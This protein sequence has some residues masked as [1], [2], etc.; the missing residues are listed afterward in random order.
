VIDAR[1][2]RLVRV[3]DLRTFRDACC[4]LA[5]GGD[6]LA[7]R[8]RLVI[9]P[10]RA[11][12]A[13]LTRAIEQ[14][15][16]P[17]DGAVLL[18]DFVVR[19]TL[20][21]RLADR[22]PDRP[23]MLTPFEREALMGVACR[24]AAENGH[25]PPFQLRPGLV[26]E[27][28]SFYDDLRRHENDVATFERK[29]LD[30]LEPGADADRGAERLVRQTRFLAEAFRNFEWRCLAEGALDEHGLR[31]HLR[32]TPAAMPW[33]HL[34]ITVR[35]RASDPHG[36]WNCDFDLLARLPGLARI[37]L[38]VTETCLAGALHER[39]HQVFPGIEE[40]RWSTHP[41]PSAAGAGSGPALLI[42]HGTGFAHV[43]RDREEEVAD[44]ARRVR[45]LASEP[46]ELARGSEPPVLERMALV[47][48]RPLP[49]VYLAQD[50]MRSAAV[51]CQTFDALPLAAE[52][53]AAALDLVFSC[54][55]ANFARTSLVAMLQSPHFRFEYGGG[56][57]GA[58]EV[59]ALD[60]ALSEAGYLGDRATLESV[61]A[62][63]HE[64]EGPLVERAALAGTVAIDVVR[65]LG[66]LR[67]PCAVAAHVD[68]LLAF[69]ERH[70]AVP[71]PDDPLRARQLRARAAIRAALHGIRA[72][73]AAYD[74]AAEAFE[75]VAAMVRRWI[76]SYTF[77]PRA[78]ESGVH[79]VDAESARYGD[80]DFV[81]LAGLVEGEWPEPPR[82]SIFYASGVLQ[83]LGWAAE[84]A[85][86]EGARNAFIDLLRLPLRRLVVSTFTLEDDTIVAASPLLDE[87][88]R[89]GLESVEKRI[90]PRPRTFEWEALGLEPVRTDRLSA[91]ALPW[92]E[93]RLS[94]RSSRDPRHRG[95][96][97][98]HEAPAFSLSALERYQ[99]CPFKFFAA[100]VLKLEEAPED[101]PALSPRA[102]GRFIHEVFQRFFEAWD[103]QGAGTIDPARI[104]DARALFEQVAEPLLV[105]LPEAEAALERTRLLG[106]AIAPGLVDVVLGIEASRPV[107]VVERLLE[108]RLD[109]HFSL[110]AS[111]GRLAPLRGVADRIDLLEGRRLRIIDYKSGSAPNVKRALQVPVYAL[112]AMERLEARDRAPWTVDEAAY[113]AFSGKRALVPVVR[114]G[115]PDRAAPLDAARARLFGVLDGIAGGDFAA[116]PHD[117]MICTWCAYPS[118]CRKDYVGDD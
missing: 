31:A 112:C 50:V 70:D 38:V 72:A 86:I 109:G 81:Q 41:G 80:F 91:A 108:Y 103:R 59:A 7:A 25:A 105:G 98:G 90:G 88:E 52:P 21:E 118:V 16:L 13:Q 83:Q 111:D 100:D 93:F 58:R 6:P 14:R 84:K 97:A 35:D 82:R 12:A 63:W 28:L 15:T 71:L 95:A 60:R 9:V 85:R 1:S 18:P 101:E 46:F 102:R 54:V 69:L 104:D 78:G 48:R 62:R 74:D 106:S 56:I 27:I 2:T 114:A 99:D 65:E 113:V 96:T 5:C 42:P 17:R 49:Y 92:A 29:A 67:E 19:D 57:L 73:H 36:L 3:P 23:R 116:R 20:Y 40:L 94:A 37:D 45:E 51:P 77:A 110:G 76:G 30:V 11:A 8:D 39:I 64:R 117:P 75:T 44:F 43:S 33:R 61:V 55:S 79:L 4:A 89:A 24:R 10:T 87:V 34:V 47:V 115:A 53:Y 68:C 66:A 32:A 26:A 22:L 107:R